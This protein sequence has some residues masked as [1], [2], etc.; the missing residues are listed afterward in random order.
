MTKRKF[1]RIA[2]TA[3]YKKMLAN[4]ADKNDTDYLT[5][6]KIEE[7]L[8]NDLKVKFDWEN[9]SFD[10]DDRLPG[11]MGINT[12]PNGLTFFG[13][14]A[15]G[16]WEHPVFFIVYWD[17]KRLRAYIPEEGNPWNTDT[18]EAYGN[19]YAEDDE[20]NLDR[21]NA[22]KRYPELY[23][24]YDDRDDFEAEMDFEADKIRLDILERLEEKV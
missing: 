9:Y 2:E 10:P 7:V 6:Y 24:D 21:V 18:N 14:W 22:K 19:A 13:A 17:G 3:L 1:A 15:G 23:D 16:D 20:V 11:L 12:L 5:G 4:L 8:G